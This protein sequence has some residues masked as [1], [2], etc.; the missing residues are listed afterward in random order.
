MSWVSY[1]N[2]SKKGELFPGSLLASTLPILMVCVRCS[3]VGPCPCRLSARW[4]GEAARLELNPVH[5]E[6]VE[7][8]ERTRKEEDPETPVSPERTDICLEDHEG[9]KSSGL[10]FLSNS[11]NDGEH[12][13]KSGL[14]NVVC[15]KTTTVWLDGFVFSFV[16]CFFDSCFFDSPKHRPPTTTQ[17]A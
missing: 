15:L 7:T 16:S 2:L 14:R 9:A 12:P 1:V 5:V 13:P 10:A 17:E 8:G 6:E 3:C 4:G 11:K